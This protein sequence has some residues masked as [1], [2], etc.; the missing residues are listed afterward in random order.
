MK[1]SPSLRIVIRI[2]IIGFCIF[3]VGHTYCIFSEYYEFPTTV[4]TS[5]R[6]SDIPFPTVTLCS[7]DS[8]ENYQFITNNE[9]I[10]DL[11]QIARRN[12]TFS[13]FVQ[14][15]SFNGKK[16]DFNDFLSNFYSLIDLDQNMLFVFYSTR[17]KREEY[18]LSS[19][20]RHAKHIYPKSP[21]AQVGQRESIRFLRP[22]GKIPP[23]GFATSLKYK[24]KVIRRSQRPFGIC[25]EHGLF[26]DSRYTQEGFNVD[27]LQVLLSKACGCTHPVHKVFFKDEPAGCDR[28]NPDEWDCMNKLYADLL[29]FMRLYQECNCPLPCEETIFETTSSSIPLPSKFSN[30]HEIDKNSSEC[31]QYSSNGSAIIEV[32]TEHIHFE[33]LSEKPVYPQSRLLA[34]I[35]RNLILFGILVLI[36]VTRPIRKRG[37]GTNSTEGEESISL[38]K[39]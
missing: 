3:L 15:C 10:G 31:S 12:V 34:D 5:L 6:V 24:T 11:L 18:E 9:N 23:S 25:R 26:D 38:N 32:Y 13:Q 36:A 22:M 1:F 27:C 37:R 35:L 29:P 17:R 28:R 16:C 20:N 8:T 21:F 19:M 39:A 4:D 14:S 33:Q 30:C 7:I 2:I